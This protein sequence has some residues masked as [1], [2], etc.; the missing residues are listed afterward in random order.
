MSNSSILRGI[1]YV[2]DKALSRV[3]ARHEDA[4]SKETHDEVSKI[5]ACTEAPQFYD[6]EDVF[7]RL[8]TAFPRLPE[9][10]YDPFSTWSRGVERSRDLIQLSDLRE[11]GAKVLEAAAGDGMTGYMLSCYGHDVTL[12]D[13]EDWRDVRAKDT[14]FVGCNLCADLPLDSDSFDLIF[15]FN[16]FEHLEAPDITLSELVRVCKQ[17][18]LIHLSFNPLYASPWGL[19]AYRSLLMPYPQFLFSPSFIDR[20]LEELNIYD[21]GKQRTTLQPLNQWR[22]SQFGNLWETSNCSVVD[23]RHDTIFSFLDVVKQFPKAFG[24]LG[25]TLE[26]LT[27]SGIHITLKKHSN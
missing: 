8:Q 21:L 1:S 27:T 26:D 6:S 20:K 23:L 14:A 10:G 24:G 4:L 25:L 22:V 12:T 2:K 9:Y 7:G 18:G 13:L 19:H 17:G 3:Q 5:L 15:S 11:P 16:A